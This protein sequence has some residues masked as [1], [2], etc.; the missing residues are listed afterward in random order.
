M[1]IFGIKVSIHHTFIWLLLFPMFLVGGAGL[2]GW[3]LVVFS[4]VL[5]HELSHALVA[6]AH[7]IQVE[8]IT[9]LPIGG[10]ARLGMMPED[11]WIETKVAAAGPGLNF[12]LAGVLFLFARATGLPMFAAGD[13]GE[14]AV[15]QATFLGMLFLANLGLGIFN[16]IPAFPMDGGR[17]LRAQLARRSGYL[18]ATRTAA[19]IGRWIAAAMALY[20]LAS[21][22]RPE[23]PTTLLLPVIAL[24]I[25]FAGKREEMMVAARQSFARG[26]LLRLFGIPPAAER[27]PTDMGRPDYAGEFGDRS[28]IIDIEGRTVNEQSPPTPSAADAFRQLAE[29]I[30]GQLGR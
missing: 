14:P 16:L 20:T 17:L 7:G 3:L 24:F 30:D 18:S 21:F 27:P 28:D 4:L 8:G 1:R 11:P 12:V 29:E 15:Y 13:S 10:V 22:V 23:L 19:R 26:G 25:Y 2:V 5:M 6:R 9:L